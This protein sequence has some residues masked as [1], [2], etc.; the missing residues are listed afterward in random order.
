[1]KV[2][3]YGRAP[4]SETVEQAMKTLF[5]KLEKAGVGML[6]YEPFLKQ[7]NGKLNLPAENVFT[8]YEDIQGKVQFL[9]SIGG[10]GTLLETVIFV[11]DSGIPVMGINTG[12]LGFLSS[13]S[14]NEIETAIDCLLE[15]KY[16]LD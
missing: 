7:I 15:N 1:M 5:Q 14:K 6:V 16:S 4:V 9:F 12:R 11:R 13:I 2:A 8:Q 10:D 3:V